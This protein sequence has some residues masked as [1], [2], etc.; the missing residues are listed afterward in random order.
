VRENIPRS[1]NAF[2]WVGGEK[3]HGTGA[4]DLAYYNFPSAKFRS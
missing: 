3:N 1:Y 4:V 2:C